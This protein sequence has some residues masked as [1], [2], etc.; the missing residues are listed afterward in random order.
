MAYHLRKAIIL[1]IKAFLRYLIIMPA[2]QYFNNLGPI[3]RPMSQ[4]EERDGDMEKGE[5]P[6]NLGNL[7]K[8]EVKSNDMKLTALGLWRNTSSTGIPRTI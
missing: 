1:A 3:I 4:S 8:H 6:H 2:N 5:G 7:R